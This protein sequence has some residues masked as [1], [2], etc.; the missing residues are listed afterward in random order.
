[1]S[2]YL[3][4]KLAAGDLVGKFLSFFLADRFKNIEEIQ[5]V[6]V[7]TFFLHGKKDDLIPFYHSKELYNKCQNGDY[8]FPNNMTHN[9]FSIVSDLLVP[10]ENFLEKHK[11]Q[12][13]LVEKDKFNWADRLKKKCFV[14]AYFLEAERNKKKKGTKG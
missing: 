3:S 1:M 6:K 10:I 4:I 7:P 13:K 2:A 8:W 14:D 12:I 11:Y 9:S 5:K